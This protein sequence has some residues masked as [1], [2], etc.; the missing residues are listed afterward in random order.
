MHLCEQNPVND[1]KGR[2]KGDETPLNKRSH[3]LL[4]LAMG[5]EINLFRITSLFFTFKT[6]QENLQHVTKI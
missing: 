6:E 1:N 5:L 3:F 4:A 2:K